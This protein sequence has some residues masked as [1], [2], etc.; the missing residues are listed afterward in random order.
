[1][2]A[3]GDTIGAQVD[4]ID[5]AGPLDSDAVEFLKDAWERHLVLRFR[6]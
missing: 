5:M 6:A 4:G 1:M 3:L 2:T